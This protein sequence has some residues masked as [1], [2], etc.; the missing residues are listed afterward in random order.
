MDFLRLAGLRNVNVGLKYDV[1]CECLCMAY[2]LESGEVT[3]S[4]VL[5][6]GTACANPTSVAL[7]DIYIG[8]EYAGV[9]YSLPLVSIV[10]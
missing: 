3:T 8:R 4:F 6:G 7:S 10:I 1:L 5:V 9:D 2:T